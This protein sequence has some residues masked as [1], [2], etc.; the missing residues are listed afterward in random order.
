[1]N[2]VQHLQPV[3]SDQVTRYFIA[4]KSALPDERISETLVGLFTKPRFPVARNL[5][6]VTVQM[7]LLGVTADKVESDTCRIFALFLEIQ[8]HESEIREQY[9]KQS[10][11]EAMSWLDSATVSV[12]N[13][14][15]F[16]NKYPV[17]FAAV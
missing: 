10:R 16:L 14:I 11:S 9:C 17:R 3:T 15:D 12:N 4:Y 13:L 1:M 6:F 5:F 2:P 8:V 7:H